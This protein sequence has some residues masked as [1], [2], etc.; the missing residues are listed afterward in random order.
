MRVY[1]D[2][3]EERIQSQDQEISALNTAL[4]DTEHKLDTTRQDLN[5]SRAFV[6]SEGTADAQHL[7]KG[8]RELNS[9]IDDFAFRFMQEV[10]PD[11]A[12]SK[13]VSKDGLEGLGK[14]FHGAAKISTFINIAYAR[15]ACVGDF[16]HPFIC[17]A[18]CIRLIELVYDPFVPGMNKEE[19]SIFK[20]IYAMVHRN[21]I[22]ERSARWR[23]ITYAH[24]QPHRNNNL[25]CEKAAD[26]F[27]H[28]MVKAIEPLIGADAVTFD[29]AKKEVGDAVKSVF[30]E[31]VKLQ[32]K[33]Q[34]GYMS[35]DYVPFVPGL[36]QPFHPAYMETAQDVRQGG[37]GKNSMAVLNLGLGMQAWKSVVKEDKSVGKDV[38]IALKAPV[39]CGN[40]NPS[41]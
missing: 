32:D 38:N 11:S 1:I 26:D 20:E 14:S 4:A 22:Q 7:I 19:S 6:S 13:E 10:L 16:I 30:L 29:H 21:E 23:A 24:S 17:Y 2:K 36:D 37:K 3:L 12:T 18:L 28:R 9:A 5:A 39:L 41:A 34:T 25:F 40:W 33:A 8:L 15:K 35:F 31:A 27:L